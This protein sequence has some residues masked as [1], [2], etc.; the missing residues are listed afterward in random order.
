M[1]KIF[2]LSLAFSLLAGILHAQTQIIA[3]RGFWDIEGSAQNSISSLKNAQKERFYGSE[4]DVHATLDGIM[5]VNHD[6]DING[7]DINTHTFAQL[8]NVRLKNGE[9]IPTLENYLKQ[10]AENPN[11]KLV[12]EIKLKSDQV[13]EDKAVAAT[14]SLVERLNMENHVEYISF[15]KY[16][17]QEIKRKSPKSIVQFLSSSPLTVLTPQEIK[18]EGFDGLDYHFLLI[19]ANPNWIKEAKELGLI[20]NVWTVN[21]EETM[22]KMMELGVDYITTDKPL[23]LRTIITDKSNK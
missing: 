4:C 19:N 23:E 20:T 3:H 1:K 15:S 7:L 8:Q 14:L 10:T 2:I 22:K 13:Q 16:I 6:N 9:S 5:V 21:D 11:T 17:C 12:I 18:K